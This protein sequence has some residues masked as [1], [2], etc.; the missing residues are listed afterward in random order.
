MVSHCFYIDVLLEV[1]QGSANKFTTVFLVHTVVIY[2]YCYQLQLLSIII[3]L[4]FS[5]SEFIQLTVSVS[6]R[7]QKTSVTIRR[8]QITILLSLCTQRSTW[9]NFDNGQYL[10]TDA[11]MSKKLVAC[12]GLRSD[13]GW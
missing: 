11:V 13:V 3:H 12:F 8:P 2:H 9:M 5:C 4:S 10:I 6:S 7:L 1:I